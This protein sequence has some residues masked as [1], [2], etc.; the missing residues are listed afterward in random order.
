[1]EYVLA[2]TKMVNSLNDTQSYVRHPI[3]SNYVGTHIPP[4]RVKTIQN[5]VI[6]T[7]ILETLFPQKIE[8]T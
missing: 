1:M 4:I 5:R 7:H 8:H 2:I 6:V 3:L